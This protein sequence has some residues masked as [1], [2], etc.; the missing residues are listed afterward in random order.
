MVKELTVGIAGLGAIGLHLAKAIDVGVPGLRLAAVSARDHAKAERN[1]AGFRSKPAIVPVSDLAGCD[2]VVEAAPAAIF[3]SVAAAAVEAGR[4]FI[5][6]SVGALLPRM[7]LVDRAKQTGA[8]VI[9]PTG[10]LLGLD[11]V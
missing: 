1:V 6:S 7:H 2:V 10:A 8:R 9:V 4:I 5:P 11:A 3:E